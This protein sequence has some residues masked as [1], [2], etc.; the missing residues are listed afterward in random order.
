MFWGRARQH[1]HI[2]SETSNG[3]KYSS[4]KD[5]TEENIQ[6]CPK[7]NNVI[8]YSLDNSRKGNIFIFVLKGIGW[9]NVLWDWVR[10]E[11]QKTLHE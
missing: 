4:R 5:R 7:T 2:C 10:L 6:I 11:K 3:K 1:T 8:K 9:K